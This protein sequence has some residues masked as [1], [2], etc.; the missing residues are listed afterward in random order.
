MHLRLNSS[1]LLILLLS[2]RL[3]AASDSNATPHWS[4]KP[5]VGPAIPSVKETARAQTPID[6]F[7]LS[8]LEKNGLTL[9]APAE[10][11]ML[12]RRIYFD[13]IGL[14]PTPREMEGFVDNNSPDAIR[15]VIDRLLDSPQYGER[16]AR[17][18]LDVVHYAETH[19]HDQDRPRINAWPYRDYVIASFN[20]DKPYARFVEEQIA[21]DFLF[22]RSPEATV[23]LGFLATGP[24]DESSLRDIREDS[25]DRQIA[26]Y[27]DR[28]DIVT[29]T[30]NTFTSIT[31]QCA[32]CH[33][34]KFDPISLKEYYGLQAVFAGTE[35]GDRY[36]DASPEVHQRRQQ[37]L[38]QNRALEN[39][40][41]EFL[42]ELMAPEFQQR[43]AGWEAAERDAL[44][45][46]KPLKPLEATG[47]TQISLR[48]RHNETISSRG[49]TAETNSY[50]VTLGADEAGITAL[51][52]ETL[53]D[54]IFPADGPGRAASG[55]FHL[56]NVRIRFGTDKAT[57]DVKIDSVAADFNQEGYEIEKAIDDDSKSGWGIYP[58]VSRPHA[59]DFK[60]ADPTPAVG[61]L[62]VE[63]DQNHGG[64]HL[65]ARFRFLA[66]TSAP[67]ADVKVLPEQISD[68]L[69]TSKNKRCECEEEDLTWF[70]ANILI[71]KEFAELPPPKLVYAGAH[72]F[73]RDGSHKPIGK[74]RPVH[75]LRRGELK[76]A[77]DL[78]EPGVLSCISGLEPNFDPDKARDEGARRAALAKWISDERNVLTWRSIVNRVW[79]YHF[80]RGI[81]GTPNDFGKMGEA[82]SH[83]ELL[84][85]LTIWFQENGGSFKNLHRLILLSAAYQQSSAFNP[86]SAARDGG[87]RLLWRMNP[88]RLDAESVR[89]SILAISGNLNPQMGGPSVHQFVMTP[90]IHVT[91][92]VDYSSFDLDS[93]AGYRRSIY[94]FVF[95]TLPDPLMEALDCPDGSQLTPTRNNS[96]TVLQALAMWN[97]RFLIRQSEHFAERLAKEVPNDIAAQVELACKLVFQRTPSA[98]EKS[99]LLAFLGKNGLPNLCR[100][101]LNSNEFMFVQ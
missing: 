68:T 23:A 2:A 85:W 91:P 64:Y 87:N 32:R 53:T 75:V 72:E 48:F 66:T 7:I 49:P 60:F 13:V 90:G 15:E 34:H 26:R 22:P 70:V 80:G 95:R 51:K 56:T 41:S 33:D 50:H 40:S 61:G 14:P 59:A 74:L 27:I 82:P 24:W 46:W 101:L 1:F 19:G 8:K 30:L 52:L 77:G 88:A 76:L 89:D 18:W 28:D 29:T 45:F 58:Q 83:P 84:D 62:L 43:V 9:S 63:L 78:A 73:V 37:L 81:V 57:N 55:N 35:K 20:D 11:R 71:Q 92:N 44:L 96:V 47:K 21:G 39:K 5:L 10:K 99:E 3:S 69:R 4:L 97:N 38:K 16:W 12:L 42:D 67:P 94:R 86:E 79:Q 17:H 65:I 36:Y 93:A 98:E 25:T 54:E 31:A 100:V 6:H